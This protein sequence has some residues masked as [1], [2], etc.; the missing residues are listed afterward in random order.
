[1]SHD[2]TDVHTALARAKS[3][4]QDALREVDARLRHAVRQDPKNLDHAKSVQESYHR[5]FKS[6]P[7]GSAEMF[8]PAGP[9]LEATPL[10]AVSGGDFMPSLNTGSGMSSATTSEGVVTDHE[11]FSTSQ[12]E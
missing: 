7:L 12:G 3:A 10:P 8:Q 11:T 2:W 6:E 4:Y 9:P 5:G 1:M